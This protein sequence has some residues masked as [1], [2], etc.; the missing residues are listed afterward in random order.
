MKPPQK[1]WLEWS[2]FAI[3]LCIVLASLGYL[4]ISAMREKNTPPDLRI[5]AGAPSESAGVHRVPLLIRNAGDS[6]AA[7]VRIEVLLRR[8][9]EVVESA[10][11]DLPFVPRKSEREG[12][13]TFR[14]DPRCCSVVTRAVSYESP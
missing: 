7:S 11:L 2:V 13:V 3:S 5:F 4:G 10:E 9:D 1:N 12:W 8:G 6:T 14:Q